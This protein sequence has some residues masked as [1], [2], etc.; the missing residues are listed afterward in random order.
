MSIL[1]LRSFEYFH[2]GKK[3]SRVFHLY[4]LLNV[5]SSLRRSYNDHSF[6]NVHFKL[7]FKQFKNV[8]LTGVRLSPPTRLAVPWSSRCTTPRSSSLCPAE[9]RSRQAA[10][11][12]PTDPRLTSSKMSQSSWGQPS[13]PDIVT[14]NIFWSPCKSTWNKNYSHLYTTWM[15]S[16]HNH[17]QNIQ[18][19]STVQ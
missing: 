16:L 1:R 17:A 2:F 7:P 5:N 8:P 10:W 11:L 6:T 19:L 9:S 14:V 4:W 18:S 13:E 3:Y 15:F 12:W